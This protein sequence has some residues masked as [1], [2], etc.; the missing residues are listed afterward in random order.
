[1]KPHWRLLALDSVTKTKVVNL[2]YAVQDRYLY[3]AS[4]QAIAHTV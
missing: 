3:Q 4:G 1:M 2:D